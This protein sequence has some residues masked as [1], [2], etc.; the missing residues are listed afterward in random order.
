M[1]NLS[2]A[3]LVLLAVLIDNVIT[4]WN[5]GEF[6]EPSMRNA[7]YDLSAFVNSEMGE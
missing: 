7:M 2:N 5:D 3:N 6:D 4:Q 1:F